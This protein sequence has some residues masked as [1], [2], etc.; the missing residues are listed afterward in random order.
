[1][2]FN[3]DSLATLLDRVYQ[4]YKSLFKPI[5]KTPRYNLL[6]VFASSDAGMYHQLLGDLTFLSDQLFPDTAVGEY[7]RLHWSDRVP[8]LYAISAVGAIRMTGV[9]G[10]AIPAGLV[11]ASATGKNYFTETAYKIGADGTVVIRV[12]A[13]EAGSAS[14]LIPDQKLR[15][16]SSI[17]AGM[18]SEAVTAEQ[19]IAG[20]TDGETDEAYLARV[21]MALRNTTRYGKPGDFAAWAVDSSP[22][23]TKAWEFKNYSVFGAL[24]IQV[25]NGN[26]IDGVHPVGNLEIVSEYITQVAPPILFTVRTPELI[27]M[28]PVISLLPEEDSLENRGIVSN[29]LLTYL[30]ATS[31]PGGSYTAG[32]LRDAIIDGVIISSAAVKINGST[33]GEI[34][35]TILQYPVLGELSWE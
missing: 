22:E 1:M 17:P 13:Q 4:N 29:R 26:Q 31:T 28:N 21:L 35:T 8:P 5:D 25:I 3:R 27:S 32:Q 10:A 30:Q 14:N 19:G 20:G 18:D 7:L 16:V 24:L 2:P 23:V 11:F 34:K 9:P 12:K 6:K 33:T 15:M